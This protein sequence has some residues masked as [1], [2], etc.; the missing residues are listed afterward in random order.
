MSL[1]TRVERLEPRERRLL[2]VLVVV[3]VAMVVLLVPASV[4]TLLASKRSDNEALRES[5]GAIQ[6]GRARV[7]KREA[8]RQQVLE[9]YARPAPP[10]AA[11]LEQQAKRSEIEIPESQDRAPIPHGKQYEERSTKIVLRR[12]GM[13]NLAKLMER[14][15][16]ARHPVTIARLNIRKRG[17]GADTYDV[18]MIVSAY[19]RKAKGEKKQPAAD[20]AKPGE[21][22]KAKSQEAEP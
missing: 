21:D 2:A 8:E 10:L 9:R 15:A 1:A 6:D 5:I 19:D 13:Y 14:V 17:T 18:Q 20:T 12:V 3:F 16:Q 4:I 22:A 11:F 7:A